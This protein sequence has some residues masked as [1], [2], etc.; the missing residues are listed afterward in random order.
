MSR[1]GQHRVPAGT[2][3]ISL[4]VIKAAVKRDIQ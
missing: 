2:V 3:V 4:P 1:E